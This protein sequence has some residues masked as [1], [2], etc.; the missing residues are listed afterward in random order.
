MRIPNFTDFV[1][2]VSI[3]L[4]SI[5]LGRQCH[6]SHALHRVGQPRG[7]RAEPSNTC[8]EVVTMR[9][10]TITKSGVVVLN[11]VLF[12]A[13]SIQSTQMVQ[14]ADLFVDRTMGFAPMVELDVLASGAAEDTFKACVARIPVFA[15]AG[16]RM[17]AEQS[18]AGEEEV[19]KTMRAA[20]KF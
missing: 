11:V 18:C 7:V 6:G 10:P 1:S 3:H 20:P 19:R 12:A 13:L 5:Q 8:E 17:L 16:Q 14:A 9:V 2:S 4:M 15:S